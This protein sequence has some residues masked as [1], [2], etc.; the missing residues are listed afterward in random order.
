MNRAAVVPAAFLALA[1]CA[2]GGTMPRRLTPAQ[3]AGVYRVCTLRF[4]PVQTA[5]P[6]ANLLGTVIDAA[7][8]PGEVE[9]SLTLSGVAAQFELVYTHAGTG[10]L[11]QVRGD[12][13]YG[14]NSVFLYLSSQTPS[15]VQQEALLPAAHLDLVYHPSPRRL[16]AGAEVSAYSV[17]RS[18]YARAAG[19]GEEGLQDRI[20][21][22]LAA[23]FAEGAC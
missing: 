23:A 15:I 19:I 21:G 6:A 17:R 1:A 5:L 20:N 12:V 16:T 13:E 8:G 11:R 9:P 10:A 2:D 7:P 4:T 18:D 3:V 22:H 14:E